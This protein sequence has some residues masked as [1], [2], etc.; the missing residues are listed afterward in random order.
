MSDPA[1][2]ARA[3]AVARI[4]ASRG[5]LRTQLLKH[6]PRRRAPGA[7]EG[8][9]FDPARRLRALWRST[10]QSLRGSPVAG[11]AM[12]AL[13]DWWQRHP[14]RDSVELV[15]GE[16]NAAVRPLVRRHPVATMTIA[17]T[18][19]VALVAGKPWR[20]PA[21]NRRLQPL[22]A[23]MGRWLFAQLG[24]APAQAL[25]SSLMVMLAARH[26]A[27][28]A[29]DAASEAAA[30]AAATKVDEKVELKTADLS[31]PSDS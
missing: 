11:V 1:D 8:P 2:T 18:V 25:L 22:P 7:P 5:Q 27:T 20:W 26:S 29:A 16:I 17:A 12:T 6:A 19:G 9:G 30:D 4:A 28:A 10:R 23:R 24:Q 14:W 13:Q 31:A 21:V 3:E 15:L